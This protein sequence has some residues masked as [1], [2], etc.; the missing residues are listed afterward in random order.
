MQ[1]SESRAGGEPQA[2]RRARFMA[3]PVRRPRFRAH[4]APPCASRRSEIDDHDEDRRDAERR[5]ERN[6]SGRALLRVD[7]LAENERRRADDLR[8]DVVAERERK[9]EDRP[10]DEARRS[11]SGKITWRNVCRGSAPR[12]S[13]ASIRVAGTRSSAA[14]IGRIM[15]GSQM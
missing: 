12:S 4:R 10:G 13:D 14:C 7:R 6:V 2:E 5:R 15:Y 8:D 11:A 1:E 3:E 9:G